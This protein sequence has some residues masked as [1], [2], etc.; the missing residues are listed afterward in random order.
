[1]WR[2]KLVL[3]KSPNYQI[4][5]IVEGSTCSRTWSEE[6][7]LSGTDTI[8]WCIKWENPWVV[9]FSA[10]RN[11]WDALIRLPECEDTTHP[12]GN[13]CVWSAHASQ[14]TSARVQH[15]LRSWPSR[16]WWWQRRPCT[17]ESRTQVVKGQNSW[18]QPSV[19]RRLWQKSDLIKQLTVQ[20][21]T[22]A[23]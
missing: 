8:I 2:Q 23:S 13:V 16:V 14:Q 19:S 3:G 4:C 6:N 11:Q 12:R 17:K 9:F 5:R 10:G 7:V 20:Y 21:N 1:M 22:A 18:A 15:L